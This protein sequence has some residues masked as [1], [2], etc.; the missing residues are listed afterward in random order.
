MLI[1]VVGLAAGVCGACG[2]PGRGA[3]RPADLG[4]HHDN[5]P[6]P[7]GAPAAGRR[8]ARRGGA[9]RTG[10]ATCSPSPR[11]S[12]TPPRSR[13]CRGPRPR[14]Q[15]SGTAAPTPEPAPA[16]TALLQRLALLAARRGRRRQCA[17]CALRC[18]PPSSTTAAPPRPQHKRCSYSPL[19]ARCRRARPRMVLFA[20]PAASPPAVSG[21]SRAQ[22]PTKAAVRR[23][24]SGAAICSGAVT[25]SALSWLTAAVRAL[26]AERRAARVSRERGRQQRFGC[27]P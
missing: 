3:L 16:D 25:N 9:Q 5:D 4:G 1:A 10:A 23:P 7:V 11:G 6:A 20:A 24:R 17:L 15:R 27:G 2:G 21:R 14:Q 8:P 12:P 22:A 19:S 26:T 18:L 13:C